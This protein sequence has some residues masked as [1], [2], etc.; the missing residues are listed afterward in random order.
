VT[1][2]EWR[3]TKAIE[4]CGGRS[5][6]RVAPRCVA[7][8]AV[9]PPPQAFGVPVP[10]GAPARAR[11]SC[12]AARD[13]GLPMLDTLVRRPTLALIALLTACA[14][15]AP[16]TPAP[17]PTA[18]APATA[19]MPRAEPRPLSET[20][21]RIVAHVDQWAD[22]AIALLEET[23]NINSGTLNPAGV[24]RVAEAMR[25]QFE[26]LG[27]AVRLAD[28]SEVERG[29]HLIA[30]RRG[31]RGTRLLLIGHLDTV[32]EED[33]PFQRWERV[34]ATTARGPGANDMK[35]GNVV[36]LAA[37]R[38]LHAAG[39][40]E[41]TRITVVLTGDEESPGRPLEISRRDLL[42]AARRSDAALGFETGSR[43]AG[44]HYAV[45]A[46]RSSSTWQLEVT[47]RA[48]HSSGIFREGVGSGAIFEA[49][50]IL[51][52]MHEELRGEPY[53]TFNP[54]V[55]VGGTEATLD[56]AEGRGTAF[57]K[58]NV[59]AERAVARGDI[60]TI[61]DEQLERTRQRMRAIVARALPRTSATIT[62]ADGYPAMAPREENYA[63]LREYDEISRALGYPT[64]EPF[65]PA[66][67]GAADIS[68]VAPL[69]PGLDGLGPFGTGAHTVEETVDI[70]SVALATRRA[71]LLIHRLTR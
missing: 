70:A 22:E 53:L 49:A 39:E 10:A 65:D 35:G 45:I 16:A 69:I 56:A 41:G 48:A 37:L 7:I 1:K 31:T 19:Q 13:P 50:R 71:A 60:R 30:E 63:L 67:R 46:R 21:R 61:S 57:G 43:A 26:A 44:H 38:A 14:P 25:P 42:E 66:G 27:F 8:D 55:V 29:P 15:A 18:A 5:L 23:V 32:F 40:L 2:D 17:A 28:M 51:T 4:K 12:F 24:R 52:A 3:M 9:L 34:D 36:I 59:V 20:E 64:V 54:G 62:F 33:S 47:G 11:P 68:F 58:T 6:D